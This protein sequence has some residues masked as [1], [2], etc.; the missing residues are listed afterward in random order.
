MQSGKNKQ[1]KKDADK[2]KRAPTAY[3]L[4]LA[5][6]RK[7]MNGKAEGR[8]IPELAGEKWRSMTPADKKKYE[9]QVVIAKKEHEIA[10]KE[11]N[12]KASISNEYQS[13][14]SGSIIRGEGF[15]SQVR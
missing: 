9:D 2:P 5:D 13:K 14:K 7:E 4:F 1:K 11:Y 6:F 8:K 12:A 10:M 15:P 3:F